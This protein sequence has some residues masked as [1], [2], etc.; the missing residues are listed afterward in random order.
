M[1]KLPLKTHQPKMHQPTMLRA[2]RAPRAVRLKA[3]KLLRNQPEKITQT[4]MIPMLS[5]FLRNAAAAN[6]SVPM[7]LL[8]SLHAADASQLNVVLLL[9]ESSPF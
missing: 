1:E 5:Q 7:N 6:A 4:T 2:L 9:L 3:P 8:R